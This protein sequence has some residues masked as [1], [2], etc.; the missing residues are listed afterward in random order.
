MHRWFVHASS[1]WRGNEELPIQAM[2]SATAPHCPDSATPT[3]LRPGPY[4]QLLKQPG[5]FCYHTSSFVL[6][7]PRRKEPCALIWV[8]CL[9]LL[10]DQS[11]S[12]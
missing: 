3:H 7:D 5:P 12:R 10:P 1:E 8:R 6:R 4:A 11:K 9:R 2:V